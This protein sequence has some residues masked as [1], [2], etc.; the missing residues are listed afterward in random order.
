[1]R[2]ANT[3]AGDSTTG[4]PALTI[5]AESLTPLVRQAVAAEFERLGADGLVLA[6]EVYSEAEL[7]A[8]LGV[9]PHV[10]RDERLRGRLQGIRVGRSIRITRADA[11]RYLAERRW[12]RE[13]GR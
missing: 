2:T 4:V 5:S 6:K 12:R 11:L 8:V 3:A 10:L 13:D 7:A 1:M 9:A